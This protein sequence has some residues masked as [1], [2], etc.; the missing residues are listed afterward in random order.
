[1][2]FSKKQ[3]VSTQNPKISGQSFIKS[4]KQPPRIFCLPST[5][6][7]DRPQPSGPRGFTRLN[8]RSAALNISQIMAMALASYL[9]R[10]V[11]IVRRRMA[12]EGDSTEFFVNRFCQCS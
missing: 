10:L 4:T 1:M 6:L 12:A 9:D 3:K 8:V 11:A 2:N 5:S 7:F